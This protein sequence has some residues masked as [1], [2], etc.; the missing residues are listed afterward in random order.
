[1]SSYRLEGELVIHI[2]QRLIILRVVERTVT[3]IAMYPVVPHSSMLQQDRRSMNS[4]SCQGPIIELICGL[5]L[6]EMLEMEGQLC[7]LEAMMHKS[8]YSL[9]LIR[10]SRTDTSLQYRRLK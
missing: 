8:M 5:C 9:L 6:A 3:G 7:A 10:W 2:T 1:M 4:D